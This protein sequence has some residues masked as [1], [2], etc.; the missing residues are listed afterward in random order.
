M[1]MS[2]LKFSHNLIVRKPMCDVH[3]LIVIRLNEL[4]ILH[5]IYGLAYNRH[6]PFTD[7]NHF[8]LSG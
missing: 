2:L 5:V 8:W 4:V 7:G 3:I 6:T 1:F